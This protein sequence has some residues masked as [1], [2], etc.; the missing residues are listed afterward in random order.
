V[1]SHPS[2]ESTIGGFLTGLVSATGSIYGPFDTALYFVVLAAFGLYMTAAV[3][4]LA[5]MVVLLPMEWIGYEPSDD[6]TKVILFAIG[7]A[8]LALVVPIAYEFALE[9]VREETRFLGG[10]SGIRITALLI[11]SGVGYLVYRFIYKP[12][13]QGS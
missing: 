6:A 7:I 9:S 4:V 5:L 8:I 12:S 11:I 1:T 13:T 2:S 10:I 3:A